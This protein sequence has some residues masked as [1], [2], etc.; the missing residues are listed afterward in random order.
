MRKMLWCLAVFLLLFC[1]SCKEK[2]ETRMPDQMFAMAQAINCAK[3]L[4]EFPE[5]AE[6][7][8]EEWNVW[9]GYSAEFGGIFV[10]TGPFRVKESFFKS[11]RITAVVLIKRGEI[12]TWPD[13][14][15]CIA[16]DLYEFQ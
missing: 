14:W 16:C 2:N 10:C 4:P 3:V 7:L 1:V 8:E 11:K 15:K 5:G 13:S 6:I 12:G 9:P